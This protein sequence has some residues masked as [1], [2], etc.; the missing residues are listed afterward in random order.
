MAFRGLE[1]SRNDDDAELAC[2]GTK[3]YADRVIPDPEHNPAICERPVERVQISHSAAVTCSRTQ[4]RDTLVIEAPLELR[5]AGQPIVVVMR[6]PG[7]DRELARGLL[8]AEGLIE[9]DESLAD[10]STPRDVPADLH[11]DVIELGIPAPERQVSRSLI[12][13]SSCGVCGKTAVADLA[14]PLQAS[15]SGLQ[16]P[17]PIIAEMPDRLRAAQAVFDATGALHAA[18]AF[19][20]GGQ[21]LAVREDVGRHNAVDKLVGWALAQRRVPCA[22]AILCVSG[23]LSFEIVQ[24]ATA[25]GFP[26]VAAVSAPSS[27]AVDLAERYRVTLC[28]FNRGGRFNVYSHSSRVV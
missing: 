3:P 16:V 10:M 22:G 26:V 1:R 14:R 20:P 23:R 24:K 9:P 8:F 27:L 18:G 15:S 28:G 11:G 6:T 25:A 19:D 17:A 2:R 4:A 21:L 12:S 5:I 7:H 13:S